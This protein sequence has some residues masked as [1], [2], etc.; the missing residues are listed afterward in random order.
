MNTPYDARRA[1]EDELKATHNL[2]EFVVTLGET[3]V[4]HVSS[5]G[6]A[7]TM[8]SILNQEYAMWQKQENKRIAELEA[9]LQ[10]VRQF[11]RY[12]FPLQDPSDIRYGNRDAAILLAQW[13]N[14]EG[15]T[16]ETEGD[17]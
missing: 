10:E 3:V 17:S 16:S 12:T 13:G 14:S 8:A 9:A 11:V 1:T 5:L 4:C 6:Y 7:S 15:E 2:H